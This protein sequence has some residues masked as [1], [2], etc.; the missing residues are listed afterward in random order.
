MA[1]AAGAETLDYKDENLQE[2]IVSKTKGEGPDHVIEAVGMESH[3]SEGLLETLQT[4]LTSTERPYALQQA[5]LAVRLGGTLS[6]PG[7]FIGPTIAPMGHIVGKG[8]T[9]K[10]GQTHVQRYLKPLMAR[11]EKGEIDPSFLITHRITLE[12]GPDAYKMFRDKADG[13]VKVVIHP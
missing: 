8:L 9:V 2:R 12:E 10:T 5:A 3:G 6:V 11:I 7:V 1:R 4:K 13:C